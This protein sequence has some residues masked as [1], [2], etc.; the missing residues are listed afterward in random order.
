MFVR[1]NQAKSGLNELHGGVSA[2]SI[3]EGEV[4]GIQQVC[5]SVLEL[6]VILP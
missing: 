1:P 4:V 6:L 3:T 2:T 5:N